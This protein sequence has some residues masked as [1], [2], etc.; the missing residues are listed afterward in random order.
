MRYHALACDYDGTLAFDGRVS[1]ETLAALERFLASGRKL[2]L[3]TGRGLEDLLS[4]FAYSNL[5]EW[6]VAENGCLLY[7]P[8]SQEIKRLVDPPPERFITELHERRVE[9]LSVG[10][11][12]VATRQP[13]ETTVLEVIRELGLELQVVF[14]K[15][16]VMVLPAGTNK[17]TGLAAALQEMSLS[18]HNVVGVG[19]AENDHP[20]LSLCEC[21]V[22]VANALPMVKEHADF[23]TEGDHGAGVSEL[24]DEIVTSDLRERESRLTRHHLL[25]RTRAIR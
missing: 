12:I 8:A 15:G 21:S 7:R 10:H 19:D 20:F 25:F 13:H 14:N 5:F 1:G 22:A 2:I 9:P 11:A 23:V 4:V 18:P 3:V 6:V 16:A 17:A 24:I